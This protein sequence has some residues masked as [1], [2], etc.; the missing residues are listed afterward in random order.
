MVIDVSTSAEPDPQ[1]ASGEPD[2]IEALRD[3]LDMPEEQLQSKLDDVV[4]EYN[5]L[6][7]R[8]AAAIIIGRTQGIR[9]VDELGHGGDTELKVENI[10]PEMYDITIKVTVNRVFSVNHFDGGR[11][12]SA[13]V[14]DSTAATQLTAWDDDVA[15][16][17]SLARGDELLIKGAY[18]QREVSDWQQKNYDGIPAMH[19]GDETE[20]DCQT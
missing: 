18:T 2:W 13:E 9:L 5:G 20:I 3:R 4:D 10:G 12:K 6:V 15:V 16:F 14:G 19:I 11:V 17:D 7:S 8:S 1:P